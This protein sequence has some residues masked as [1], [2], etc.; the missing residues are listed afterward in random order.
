MIPFLRN[1]TFETDKTKIDF[2]LLNEAIEMS[3]LKNFLNS[4]EKSY[5]VLVKMESSYQ[6]VNDKGPY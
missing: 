2:D 6:V 3:Q 4:N 1:I 5:T